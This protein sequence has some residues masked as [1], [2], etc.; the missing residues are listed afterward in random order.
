MSEG[1]I[2]GGRRDRGRF[3]AAV[4]RHGTEPD[5]RFTFANERTFLAWTRTALALIAGG[6]ALEVLGLDMQ[7]TL[8][9]IASVV[10][11]VSGIATPGLAWVGWVRSERALRLGAPL[12]SS[13]LAVVVAC[14]V[15]VA[16]ALVFVAILI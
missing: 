8:R 7:P 3:P 16:G 12:P 9:L 4:F 5:V 11:I 1:D 6:V 13:A 15:T 14:A 10:L 2:P